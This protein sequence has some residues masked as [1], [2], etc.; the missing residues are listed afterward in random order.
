MVSCTLASLDTRVQIEALI[1]TGATGYAFIDQNLAHTIARTMNLLFMPL[2]K[3]K[4]IEAFDG[5]DRKPITHAI[6]LSLTVAGRT[7]HSAPLLIASLGKHDVIVGKP[8]MNQQGAVLDM[9]DDSVRFPPR[10][11]TIPSQT[12]II[13]ATRQLPARLLPASDEK[14]EK[15]ILQWQQDDGTPSPP[16][17]ILKRPQ[18]PDSGPPAPPTAALPGSFRAPKKSPKPKSKSTG[19][20]RWLPDEEPL[21]PNV[22]DIS[23]VNAAAFDLLTKRKGSKVFALSMLEIDS[24]LGT[25]EPLECNEIET[26]KEWTPEDI[27]RKLP[28]E[29]HDFLDIFE[30]QRADGLPPHREYDHRIELTGKVSDLPKNKLYPMS[31]HKLQKVKEYLDENLAKGYITPTKAAYAS[32]ILFVQK[33]D[34]SLRFCVDYRKLNQITKRNRYPLPLIEETMAKVLGCKYLTK[35]DIVAAFNRLRMHPDSEEWT[36]FLTAFGAYCYKVMPFGLT[37]GPASWQNFINDVLFEFLHDFCQAY[38]DDILIY[39]KTLA[40]HREHV[41]KVLARLREAG[42]QVDIKKCEFH[43]EETAFLGMIV[44]AEGV[45]MDPAKVEAVLS[46]P[47]PLNLKQVQAFIGFC[48]FYRRFIRNFSR[49]VRP[50]TQLSQ[51]NKAFDWTPE[52]EKAFESLKVIVTEAP[53]LRHF[54]RNRQ[55]ILECDSS[56]YVNG[57]VLSQYDDAGVL[58]PVAYYSKSLDPAQCN[59]DIYDK[60]LLAIIHALEQWQADLE[61]T[62]DPIKIFTDHKNLEYFQTSRKLNKRQHRWMDILSDYNF[63]IVYREGKKNA[64]ADALTRRAESKPIGTDDAREKI[65]EQV[66]LPKEKFTLATLTA[67]QAN[68]PRYT[69]IQ[70]A[71]RSD[72]ACT[73]VRNALASKDDVNVPVTTTKCH[74]RD[75]VLFFNTRLWV[76]EGEVTSLIKEVHDQLSTGHP[77]T[78][79][80][81]E[82]LKRSYFWPKMKKSVAQYCRNCHTCQRT[83]PSREKPK[84]LLKPLPV[85]E[86]R[87]TDISIDFVTGIPDHKGNNAILTVVDRLSKD[88]KYIPCRAGD[89]GTS[90]S[91]TAYLLIRDVYSQHGL[92]SS[93]VS[94]RG[95]QFVSTVWR[96]LCRKLNIT[97][98]LSTAFHPETDGQTERMNAEIARYLRAF[99]NHYQDNWVD[100]LPMAEFAQRNLVSATTKMTPF[101]MNHG[102]HPRM[103]FSPDTAIYPTA[104]ER[105][106][107]RKGHDI[108]KFMEEVTNRGKQNMLRSQEAMRRS[109]NRHR[110]DVDFRVG[111]YVFLSTKN[112]RTDR[113]SRKLDDKWIGPYQI[114]EEHG[115]AY[116]LDLPPSIAIHSS[117]H[118]SLL[119]RAPNDALQGQTNDPPRPVIVDKQEHWG[120]D[121]IL[122]SR[123]WRGRLQFRVKWTGVEHDSNWYYADNGEFDDAQDAIDE[124]YERYPEATRARPACKRRTTW[125]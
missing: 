12:D 7:V 75:G 20:A 14:E 74:N 16:Y 66:L 10:D 26:P 21:D 83:K 58:H 123:N 89:E 62:D 52:C 22:D 93:I 76:P 9:R 38:V 116:K 122:A 81:L 27:K 108:A 110:K 95:R 124:Y 25:G 92:P 51:K 8:W 107:A 40:E 48:N 1:D 114:L 91:E 33:K 24:Y 78:N 88:I 119:R 100:L 54:D 55:A 87:W 36:A 46:W 63:N 113:P 98:K 70:E 65:R 49:I 84:G 53:V 118:P 61:C 115:G 39:S 37:N 72:P 125:A 6:H 31:N 4:P 34:G 56:D 32:P 77:G 5:I 101:Y 43:V 121:E 96:A 90:A 59:Y 23:T 60:E 2:R 112:L 17:H 117:F 103:S 18:D 120:V 57:G 104:R 94:D 3:P 28:P 80:T 71:N 111:D 47:Q 86:Q 99:C 44:S 67:N 45:R 97:V 29:Y 69:R 105:R 35:L 102:Y 15:P 13:T 30:K 73:E 50:L 42:L 82:L 106:L 68:F 79:R 19:R 109:A 41:R 64:K 85:P 11:F